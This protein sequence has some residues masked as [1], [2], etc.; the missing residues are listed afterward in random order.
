MR[1]L[2]W[3]SEDT[4]K[5]KNITNTKDWVIWILSMKK[6]YKDQK[7]IGWELILFNY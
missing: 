3:K 5:S 4:Q 7:N 1:A 2:R 6:Q